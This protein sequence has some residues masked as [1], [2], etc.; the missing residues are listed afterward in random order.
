MSYQAATGLYAAFER[1][2]R[3]AARRQS[4]QALLTNPGK[5]VIA[6]AR[7]SMTRIIMA[8][9]CR[10]VQIKADRPDA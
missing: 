10:A 8:W 1:S 4:A 7:P 2:H 3:S 5:S 9:S 6:R